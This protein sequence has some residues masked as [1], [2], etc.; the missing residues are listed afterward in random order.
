[1]AV[2]NIFEIQSPLDCDTLRILGL[3]HLVIFLVSIATNSFLLWTYC[4]HRQR[5]KSINLL[6]VIMT[7]LNL[8]GSL[9][10]SPFVV[11]SQLHCRWV[12]KPYSC[13]MTGFVMYFVGCSSM[14]L[15]ASVSVEQF[16]TIRN[17]LING[18]ITNQIMLKISVACI[19]LSLF[20]ALLPVFGFSKYTLEKSLTSCSVVWNDPTLSVLVYNIVILVAV[21]MIPLCVILTCNIWVLIMVKNSVIELNLDSWS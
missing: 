3:I 13:T 11:L 16:Y 8:F 1:M 7:V 18:R 2:E 21:Y 10:E 19:C 14:Y 12:F 6:V 15:L 4:Y 9:L 20:W 5:S 17:S